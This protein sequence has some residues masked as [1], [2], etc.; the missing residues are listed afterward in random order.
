MR[1]CSILLI[2]LLL[3]SANPALADDP[4]LTPVPTPT[5]RFYS[6]AEILSRWGAKYYDPASHMDLDVPGKMQDTFGEGGSYYI[7]FLIMAA[8][9]GSLQTLSYV[10]I[11]IIVIGF[12][13]TV[14][15]RIAG[16]SEAAQARAAWNN[17]PTQ[18]TKAQIGWTRPRRGK[19]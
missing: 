5:Q 6:R 17:P 3:A 19:R 14:I 15:H 16:S 7:T 12:L 4:T 11:G 1:F 8:E 10:L 9:N 13:L 18:E 2:L